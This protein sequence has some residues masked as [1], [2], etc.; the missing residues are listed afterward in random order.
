MNKVIFQIGLLA[1]CISAVVYASLGMSLLD[2]IARAFIIFI[3]AIIALIA[4]LFLASLFT[5]KEKPIDENE[6]HAKTA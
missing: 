3:I 4:I 6:N 2:V 1:F 5:V